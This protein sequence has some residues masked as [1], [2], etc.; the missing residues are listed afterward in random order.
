MNNPIADEDDHT[1]SVSLEMAEKVLHQG[2]LFLQAQFESAIASDQRAMTM[3]AFFASVAAAIAAGA[4]AYWDKS[5]DVPILIAGL[6][7]SSLMAVGACVCLWAARPV[8]FYFPGSHP[9]C[10]ESVLNRPLNEVLWGEAQNYQDN[11][12]KNAEFLETNGKMLSRGAMLSAASPLIAIAIWVLSAAISPSY[13][14]EL[15]SDDSHSPSSLDVY[16]NISR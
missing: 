12:E 8:D 3:A 10:W 5:S 14:A 7:G 9:S 4:I 1:G 6:S 16:R 11:I 2:E 15:V 13:P